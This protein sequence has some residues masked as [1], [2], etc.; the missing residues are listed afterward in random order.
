M[1]DHGQWLSVAECSINIMAFY[2]LTETGKVIICKSI[3]G[4]SIE[5]M[6]T[7]KVK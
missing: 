1:Q 6:K 3:W 5:K 4:F 2:I 7:P